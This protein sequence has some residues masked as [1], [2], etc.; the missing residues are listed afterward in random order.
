MGRTLEEHCIKC[1]SGGFVKKA[2]ACTKESLKKMTSYLYSTASCGS[3]YQ[4]A[5]LLVSSLLSIG[6]GEVFFIRFNHVKT[7]DEKVLSLFPDGDPATYPPLALALALIMQESPRAGL[8]KHLPVKSKDVPSKLTDSTLGSSRAPST[9]FSTSAK[10]VVGIHVLVNRL[11]DRVAGPA[12]VED[13]HVNASSDLTTQW[14]FDRGAWNLT[15]TT[16]AL[17]Y[18]MNTPKEDHQVAKI[19][20]RQ[21]AVLPSLG[22]F[23]S[24][25]QERIREVSCKLFNGSH[26]LTNKAFN[27]SSSVIDVLTATIIH[28]YPSLMKFN[29][30]APAMKTIQR[31]TEVSDV[32]TTCLLA[33]SQQ[34]ARSTAQR[35]PLQTI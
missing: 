21:T 14:I 4:D 11:L 17:A 7:F 10:P 2:A 1:E 15:T 13:A 31:C 25:T 26:G 18:V 3:D 32:T 9:N 19:S 29:A 28:H 6:A 23:D 30:E 33:W 34:L 27:L 20:P 8:L 24:I 16:K 5:A 12:G 35:K 22:I